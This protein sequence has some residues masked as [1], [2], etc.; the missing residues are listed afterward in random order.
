MYRH[1]ED[2]EEWGEMQEREYLGKESHSSEG[3][4]TAHPASAIHHYFLDYLYYRIQ[5][6]VAAFLLC[7]NFVL[8]DPYEK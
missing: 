8:D 3:R 1:F 6:C 2:G 7:P 5:I 4:A